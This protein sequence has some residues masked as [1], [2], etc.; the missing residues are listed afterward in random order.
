M[1]LNNYLTDITA[2]LPVYKEVRDSFVN[3]QSPPASTTVQ[4]SKLALPG[5]VYEVEAIAVLPPR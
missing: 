2:H 1:K 4:V 3:T 5:A